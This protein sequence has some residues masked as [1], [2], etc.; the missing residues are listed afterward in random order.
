MHPNT[1]P[2]VRARIAISHAG[3][4]LTRAVSLVAMAT[5]YDKAA[6][7]VWAADALDRLADLASSIAE[8]VDALK[9]YGATVQPRGLAAEKGRFGEAVA[10][11]I[12]SIGAKVDGRPHLA[13]VSGAP[14]DPTPPE[15]A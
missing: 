8:T 11:V 10:A 13:V 9:E 7:D 5:S 1:P 15:A 2:D 6:F 3:N 12:D 4:H 14:T